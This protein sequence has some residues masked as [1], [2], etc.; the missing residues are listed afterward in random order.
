MNNLLLRSL[1]LLMFSLIPAFS[2]T[3]A[4]AVSD[5]LIRQELERAATAPDSEVTFTLAAS[6]EEAF[7][8]LVNRLPEYSED[9][10]SASLDHASSETT[11]QLDAG[12]DRIVNL[13]DGKMLVHRFLNVERPG[14]FAYLTDMSRSTADIPI[15]Y[16][17]VYYELTEEGADQTNL[18]V[19]ATFKSSSSL[20]SLFVRRAFDSALEADFSMAAR[21]LAAE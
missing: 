15:D 1:A 2:L 3:A 4:E 14:S 13:K 7:D 12:S 17:I 18:R 8:F 5:E 16:S 11:N 6:I 20:L 10:A 19:A 21:V 9:V